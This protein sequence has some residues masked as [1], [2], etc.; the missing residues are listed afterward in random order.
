MPAMVVRD[1]GFVDPLQSVFQRP[2]KVLK[3]LQ[4]VSRL[5]DANARVDRM[6]ERLVEIALYARTAQHRAPAQVL[7]V[8]LK[9]K[10]KGEINQ[11]LT[12]DELV[13]LRQTFGFLAM[14]YA[15]SSALKS[16][17]LATDQPQFYTL[18]TTL[19]STDVLTR[20]EAPEL[21]RRLAAFG[22]VID[23]HAATEELQT[24]LEEYRELSVRTTTH[25]S[26][27]MRR[28]AILL[29]FVNAV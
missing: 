22:K 4:I 17:K 16:S 9:G 3:Q 6:W 14:A 1:R 24:L 7:S 25:P 29:E 26:R 13:A 5:P 21:I 19:L 8:F 27:R 28:Q 20:F 2:P 12:K 23:T 15:T 18:V 10:G 11:K